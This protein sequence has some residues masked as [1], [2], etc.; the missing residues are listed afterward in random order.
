VANS[1]DHSPPCDV[2]LLLRTHAEARWLNHE[3]VPV[4]RELEQGESLPR[5][6]LSAALA[7]LEAIWIESHKRA[8]ETDA[9]Y[10]ELDASGANGDRTLHAT[11][12]AYHAALRR[13]R[14]SVARRAA[15]L[16]GLTRDTSACSPLS[17]WQVGS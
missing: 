10:A 2:C 8:V 14:H 17:D 1:P 7:Y 3:V 13:L 12:R 5:E 6:Q 9:A 15:R 11:A 4:L 16:L